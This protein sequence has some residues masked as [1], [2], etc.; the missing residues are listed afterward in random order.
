MKVFIAGGAGFIGSW[1]FDRLPACDVV[2]VDSLEPE[3]HGAEPRF[4]ERISARAQCLHADLIE[5]ARYEAALEGADVVLHLAA[6]TRTSQSMH[7]ISRYVHANLVG[8]AQLL[9]AIARM[10]RRPAKIVLA[11]SRAVYGEG[12]DLGPE[13]GLRRWALRD[14]DARPLAPAPQVETAPLEPVSV[15]GMTKQWQEQLVRTAAASLGME[16]IVLRLQNVYGPL[17]RPA[18]PHA[19]IV[20]Y[21][22]HLA[23]TGQPIELFEDGAPTRDYVYVEDVAALLCRAVV[24]PALRTATVNVGTGVATTLRELVEVLGD[25]LGVAPDVR[26]VGRHRPGDVRHAVASTARCREYFGCVPETSL[27]EGIARY[28]QW[29]RQ[30]A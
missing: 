28:V 8:T 25:A 20:A 29:W 9:E 1:V 12:A 5:P 2:V 18:S 10:P 27:R 22:L 17:R 7:E 23:A 11:S 15:Y 21:F 19:G 24:D 14:D 16:G 13:G 3:V 30:Q 4:P 6:L 26:V